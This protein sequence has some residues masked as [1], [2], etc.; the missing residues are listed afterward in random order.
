MILNPSPAQVV[1]PR[2]RPRA[3][4]WHYASGY[5]PVFPDARGVVR[6]AKSGHRGI[7]MLDRDVV[8]PR[9][10]RAYIFDRF[11]IRHNTAFDQV[12][13][14][15]GNPDRDREKL[16][17][18]TSG[19]ADAYLKLHRL[20]YAHS[21]EAW[22]DG[23]LVGGVFGIQIGGYATLDSMF[24]FVDN[25]SKAAYVHMLRHLR[26]RGFAFADVNTVN[27]FNVRFGGQWVPQWQFEQ[28]LREQ[29]PRPLTL[30]DGARAPMLPWQFKVALSTRRLVS[31]LLRNVIPA[32]SGDR[33]TAVSGASA[34][35]AGAAGSAI[36]LSMPVDM[37]H[38][39]HNSAPF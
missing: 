5:L 4:L 2:M 37:L 7:Q 9:K 8:I 38:P 22:Q 25:A 29:L 17:W 23:C 10:Q 32:A 24:H 19:L 31:K 33:P 12:V 39:K 18:V 15:C 27:D 3:V 6:W 16:T 11:E 1:G 26:E 28:L 36:A 20:G 34:A 30:D 21:F 35:V 13:R 14:N